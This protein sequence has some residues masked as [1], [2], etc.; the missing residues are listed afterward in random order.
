M[1]EGRY[2]SSARLETVRAACRKHLDALP[3]A[4]A[5]S[6]TVRGLLNALLQTPK[7]Q[8]AIETVRDS[9]AAL[10]ETDSL[11]GVPAEKLF[12]YLDVMIR[13][14]KRLEQE[15]KGP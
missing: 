4:E 10:A 14:A 11:A 6:L 7:H 13:R 5:A 9:F 15:G 8:A 2:F 12:G 3:P 1:P